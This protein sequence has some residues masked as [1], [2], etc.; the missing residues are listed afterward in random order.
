MTLET[1]VDVS[2]KISSVVVVGGLKVELEL[3]G[4][5]ESVEIVT[6]PLGISNGVEISSSFAVEVDEG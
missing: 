5:C 6:T 3:A 4:C 1:S 2:V